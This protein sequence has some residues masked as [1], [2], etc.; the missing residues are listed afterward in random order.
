MV[1]DVSTRISSVQNKLRAILV[2]TAALMQGV[3]AIELAGIQLDRGMRSPL[4]LRQFSLSYALD[5]GACQNTMQL[6]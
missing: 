5:G 4:I 1:Y 3:A 2:I 6:G